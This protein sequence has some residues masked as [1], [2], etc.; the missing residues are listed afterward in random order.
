[1]NEAAQQSAAI[2][3]ARCPFTSIDISLILPESFR[4]VSEI[5][6]IHDRIAYHDLPGF[7][8][9]VGLEGAKVIIGTIDDVPALVFQGLS[10]FHETGDPSLMSIPIETLSLLGAG[11]VL[12]IDAAHS[13]NADLQAGTFVAISD[14]IN[15]TGFDP[16]IGEPDAVFDMT[17]A[18]D[19][20][21]IRRL[22]LAATTAMTPMTE[23]VL[24]WFSGP[25]FQTPAEA[26]MARA[27]GA[28]VIG[29]TLAPEAI[30][31]RRHGLAFAALGLVANYA[32]G[33]VGGKPSSAQIST[34]FAA[35][36]GPLRRV[37]TAFVRAA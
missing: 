30:L 8:V 2:I 34:V 24:M 35:N 17:E 33:F 22:K 19:K 12:T 15:I 20:R 16:L 13:V 32:A 23:G 27:L 26:R 31:A 10:T 18:Y 37:L 1:M 25:T 36:V 7:P 21:L 3:G 14:H 28:D 11:A 4:G 6:S 29:W 9:G 5:L